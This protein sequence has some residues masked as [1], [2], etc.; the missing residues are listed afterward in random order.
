MVKGSRL[1]DPG[2]MLSVF[3]W[4]MAGTAMW[5]FAVLFPDRFYRGII[6]SLVAANAGAIFAGL[7]GAGFTLPSDTALADAM[8]GTAGGVAALVLSWLMGP[9]YDP[10]LIDE[11]EGRYRA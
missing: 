6:G 4:V 7:A 8:L 2:R 9:R 11:A 1:T 10:V 5:H 3:V